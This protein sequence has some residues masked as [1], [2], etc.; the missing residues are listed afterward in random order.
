MLT[1]LHNINENS[2]EMNLKN[3]R[4]QE[5][6]KKKNKIKSLE[7]KDTI[8]EIKI[9]LHGLNVKMKVSA[10]KVNEL[11]DIDQYKVSHLKNREKKT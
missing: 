1:V 10:E 4:F 2:L 11:T 8:S 7:V 9:M 5:G 6:N 3:G